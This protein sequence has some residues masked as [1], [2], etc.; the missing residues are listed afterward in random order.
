MRACCAHALSSALRC[1][2]RARFHP[3]EFMLATASADR[4]ARLWDLENWS[5]VAQSACICL[6][7]A[8]LHARHVHGN[9]ACCVDGH[10]APAALIPSPLPSVLV[11][12]LCC[13]ARS[14]AGRLARVRRAVLARRRRHAARVR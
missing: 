7:H 13:F 4:T 1:A 6:R 8:A 12:F 9:G 3:H 5:L 11:S 2:R 14:A 10:T